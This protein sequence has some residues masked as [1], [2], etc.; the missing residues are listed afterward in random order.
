MEVFINKYKK[1]QNFE[2]FGAS[3]AW[4]AQVVGGWDKIDRESGMPVKD[5][6]SQLLYNKDNGIGLRTYRY[7]LGAGSKESGVGEYSDFARRA[8][9]FE[10]ENG[11]YDFSKDANAV[12]MMRQA[13]KDGADEIIFFVNSPI[14]RLTKNHKAHLDKD[15]SFRTNL[16]RKNYKAFA[17]YCLDVTEHFVNEGL[18][19]K[20]LSPINEPLWK[21]TGGQEGCHYSPRQTSKV[22]LC[23]AKELMMR[24][25]LKDVKLS[26]LESGDIRRFNKT[27][28]KAFLKHLEVRSCVDSVD[29]HS[30]CLP[31]GHLP[32]F[33]NDRLA[34][35]KRYK[36]WMDRKYPNMP[37]KMS[38]WCHMK[39]GRDSGMNSALETAKV[40]YEDISLLN[41][42]SWQHWIACSH[43]DYC[44]GLIYLNLEEQSFELTK[45][46]FVTGNFSKYIPYN[47]AR[48]EVTTDDP[49][50]KA[51]GFRNEEKT[52]LIF[53]NPSDTEKSFTLPYNAT[54]VVTDETRSLEEYPVQ[55]NADIKISAKSVNTVIFNS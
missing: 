16:S 48:V 54:L 33:F 50:V 49:D 35:V 40:I 36:K 39:G 3:G 15:K 30:Y 55:K 41:V 2:G 43:Y 4:W 28:T 52:V 32:D 5:K 11:K 37:I 20:Y 26:G 53:I 1:F 42:T 47:S 17:K 25:A 22:M 7:N 21:W 46:Y 38:E 12:Y 9:C 34:F 10:T 23:F 29:I 27:Y 31:E 14:E 51:L 45:R 18:P 13:V 6:I 44:D 19:I 24:D 8:E